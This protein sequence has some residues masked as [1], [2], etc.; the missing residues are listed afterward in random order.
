MNGEQ[1]LDQAA[2]ITLGQVHTTLTEL[3][4]VVE[5]SLVEQRAHITNLTERQTQ[6]EGRVS[7]HDDRL[8]LV[9]LSQASA[10]AVQGLTVAADQARTNR[11]PAWVS[12]IIAASSLLIGVAGAAVTVLKG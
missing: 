1:G 6:T 5:T 2:R 12:I 9:E 11:T 3:K 7:Q 8:R 4:S 10:G